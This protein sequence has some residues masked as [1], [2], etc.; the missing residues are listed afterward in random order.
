MT[1]SAQ[2]KSRPRGRPRKSWHREPRK[3][4]P[5]LVA[6]R[7]YTVNEFCSAYRVSRNTAYELMKNGRLKYFL[8]NAE[9]RIPVEA[10]E[11][12]ATPQT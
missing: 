6:R 1:E 10:A 9:R 11:A 5:T 8:L 7:A 12:L 4:E 3:P 2:T